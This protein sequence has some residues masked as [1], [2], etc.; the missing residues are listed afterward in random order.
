MYEDNENDAYWIRLGVSKSDPLQEKRLELLKKLEIWSI[1][2]FCIKKGTSPVDGRLLAF[3]RVFNMDA[4]D[5]SITYLI[6]LTANWLLDQLDHW[7]KSDK[8]TDLQHSECALD[9]SLEK[10]S[11]TFLKTRLNLLLSSY[12]SSVEEDEQLLQDQS[13]SANAKVAIRMRLTEK[14]LLKNCLGYAEEMFQK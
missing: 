9:T 13:V 6:Q 3:L 10:K 11:W 2:D 8:V 12:K 1:A 4:G 7:L 5:S 14:K